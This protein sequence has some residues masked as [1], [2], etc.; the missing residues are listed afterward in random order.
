M[1]FQFCRIKRKTFFKIKRNLSKCIHSNQG[2][3]AIGAI[4]GVSN[5]KAFLEA[6][7]Y[8]DITTRKHFTTDTWSLFCSKV[9]TVTGILQLYEQ[10]K[11]DINAPI[12]TPLPELEKFAIIKS[13][14]RDNEQILEK[15][16][17]DITMRMLLTHIASFSYSYRKLRL[18]QSS[19][20]ERQD[21]YF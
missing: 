2:N 8:T 14:D 10:E 19:C 11:L 4:C 9:I 5:D 1:A 20:E 21:R 15:S 13:F 17:E 3:A 6:N 16:L 18:P 12:K 7:D